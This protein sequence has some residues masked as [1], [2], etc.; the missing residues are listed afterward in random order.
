M[1]AVLPASQ[2]QESWAQATFDLETFIVR[3]DNPGAIRLP[4]PDGYYNAYTLTTDWSSNGVDPWSQEAIWAIA[5][6]PSQSPS[7]TIFA[8]PGSAPNYRRDDNPVTL[9]WSGL[10]ELPLTGPFDA[11]LLVFQA[12]DDPP[13]SN[14][15]SAEWANTVLELMHVTPPEAPQLVADLASS[16][17]NSA[18]S[19]CSARVTSI[20]KS[21]S[22]HR[23]GR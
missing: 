6:G 16:P 9:Q 5:D 2:P 17:K 23:P 19:A 11:S 22:T 8:D 3:S 20:R 7:T 12:F 21:A 4:V 13:G 10:L 18:L 14:R 1:G 15:F